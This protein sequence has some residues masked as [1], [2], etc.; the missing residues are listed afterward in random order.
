MAT[1]TVSGTI[2]DLIGAVSV[3]PRGFTAK[4]FLVPYQEILQD[5]SS[6]R[7]G[8]EELTLDS[9]GAFSQAG[10]QGGMAYRVEVHY[11]DPLSRQTHRVSTPY[12]EL[13]ANTN[14]VNV[15]DNAPFDLGTVTSGGAFPAVTPATTEYVG[16][17]TNSGAATDANNLVGHMCACP[18]YVKGSWTAD[19]IAVNVATAAA[20][21]VFRMGI[22]NSAAD[23]R[24]GTLV[25]DGGTVDASTTGA[26]NASI[27]QAVTQGVYWLVAVPQ[28]VLARFS[29]INALT[30]YPL[31]STVST[32]VLTAVNTCWRVTG[33][34]GALPTTPTWLV[35]GA[36]TPSRVP[37]LALRSA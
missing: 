12:F 11:Y 33:V 4:A 1:W 15:V 6:V 36:T 23:G 29:A 10:I 16:S 32:D 35:G 7:V 26:K 18:V 22:Y 28:V 21:A 8:T 31:T 20:T 9:A 25:V 17:W 24:P 2:K 19:R 27:S 14:I 13:N 34:T 30:A 5:G 37:A 3:S